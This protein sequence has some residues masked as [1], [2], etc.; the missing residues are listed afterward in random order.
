MVWYA[1]YTQDVIHLITSYIR[2]RYN[3]KNKS[4]G[5]DFKY[6]KKFDSKYVNLTY[7]T[8]LYLDKI[9]HIPRGSDDLPYSIIHTLNC[10]ILCN[11]K[12]SQRGSMESHID[13]IKKYL[14]NICNHKFS[15]YTRYYVDDNSYDKN[16][17][18]GKY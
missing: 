15:L 9:R 4:Y 6:H 5:K 1:R 3:N 16:H 14:N 7:F 18:G 13:D 2:A 8:Y 17:N 10:I 11:N 12:I